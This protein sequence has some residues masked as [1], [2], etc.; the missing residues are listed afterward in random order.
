MGKGIEWTF[1]PKKT[2]KWPDDKMVHGKML[3]VTNHQG[4]VNQIH[5]DQKLC[6]YGYYQKDKRKM[7]ARIC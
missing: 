3:N 6:Q 7:L 5:N 2:Y 4:N 1:F